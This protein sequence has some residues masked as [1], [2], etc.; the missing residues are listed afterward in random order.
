MCYLLRSD[1]RILYQITMIRAE[2]RAALQE[3]SMTVARL[4]NVNENTNRQQLRRKE[5]KGTRKERKGDTKELDNSME[6]WVY[7]SVLQ[8]VPYIFERFTTFTDM[9]RRQMMSCASSR[10]VLQRSGKKEERLEK[11]LEKEGNT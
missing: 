1:T 5:G 4:Y 7:C 6:G 11:R 9:K 8:L 2:W 3:S 10:G